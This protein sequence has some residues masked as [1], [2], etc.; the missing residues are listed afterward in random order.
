MARSR[1]I[2]PG[3]FTNPEVVEV[4][5]E[6][7]LLFIAL[8]TLADREGRLED[9]P[10]KIKMAAF[11]ADSVD[12][13][14]MLVELADVGLIERYTVDGQR[15]INIPNF[16]KHQSPH[17]K[18]PA[19]TLPPPGDSPRQAPDKPETDQG[20]AALIP[21]SGFLIPDSL[22]AGAKATPRAKD[23]LWDAVMEV[24]GLT[25]RTPTKS[26]RGGWNKAVKELR[27]IGATAADIH[28]RAKAYRKNWPNVSLT[29]NALA[30]RWNEC[31]PSAPKK[32]Q[33]HTVDPDAVY[34]RW[35]KLGMPEDLRRRASE[36]PEQWL[37]RLE[38]AA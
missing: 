33:T 24:C 3:F 26:E 4:N 32:T 14:Q 5:F 7:R 2:K 6:T 12:I 38:E 22:P 15:L 9:R 8:W 13:E 21:D 19:S 37:Q 20:R 31:A 10:K 17:H 36:T 25:D 16:T 23:E 27:D 35:V 11:P 1:N 29:P 18:E 34:E 30:R 28:A